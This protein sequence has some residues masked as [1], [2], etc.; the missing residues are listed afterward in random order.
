M[1]A[2][3]YYMITIIVVVKINIALIINCAWEEIN[4]CAYS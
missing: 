1:P 3:F 2:D 4:A